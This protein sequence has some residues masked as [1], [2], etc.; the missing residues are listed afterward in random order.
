MSEHVNF[1]RQLP[2]GVCFAHGPYT[3]MQCPKWPACATDPQNPEFKKMGMAKIDWTGG[4]DWRSL[5]VL[6]ATARFLEAE[7]ARLKEQCEAMRSALKE[8]VE[9]N[10]LHGNWSKQVED[11]VRAALA[12]P[13]P[14]VTV[15]YRDGTIEEVKAQ[16]QRA[17]RC[18]HPESEFY[19]DG[20]CS[21]GQVQCAET[22]YC[23][24]C[25]RERHPAQ[26]QGKE[27]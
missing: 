24:A 8:C 10:R 13:V 19:A 27:M 18:Q 15:E 6:V 21:C 17:K 4:I 20:A 11:I 26:P 3:E 23:H 25:I 9:W 14:P 22:P 5:D 2:G 12:E 16:P 1:M 7:N